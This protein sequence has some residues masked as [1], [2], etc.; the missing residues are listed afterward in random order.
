MP[1][2]VGGMDIFER[3]CGYILED[4]DLCEELTGLVEELHSCQACDSD[5][6]N[7]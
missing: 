2:T 5:L 4:T 1:F 3:G 7:I 6:C